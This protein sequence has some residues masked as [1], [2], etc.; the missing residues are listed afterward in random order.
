LARPA[1][2]LGDHATTELNRFVVYLA[3]PALLFDI[4]AKA[5]WS[6]IWQPAFIATFGLGVAVVFV[7]ALGPLIFDKT[8]NR[9]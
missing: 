1:R 2:V 7:A 6:D 3:L 9:R 5:R 4:I 8:T